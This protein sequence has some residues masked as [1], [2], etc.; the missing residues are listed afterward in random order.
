MMLRLVLMRHAKSSWDSPALSD[1]DRPLNARGQT[2]A[3]ALGDWIRQNGYVPQ[4]AVVSS[5]Q[6]TIETFEGLDL[7]ITAAFS[8]SLY[9]ASAEVIRRAL[10]NQTSRSVL[11]IAHNPGIADCASRLVAEM[12]D[13]ERFLDYPTGA[14]LVVD[15]PADTWEDVTWLS[16]QVVDFVVP[17]T[18]VG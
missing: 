8:R 7:G 1:F 10:A 17:R 11:L 3:Q 18:L 4:A 15:F 12:P 2:S 9:L 5:A 6:R 13:H 14:T 16:G